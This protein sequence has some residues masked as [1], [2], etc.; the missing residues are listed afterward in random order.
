[1]VRR[2]AAPFAHG[3]GGYDLVEVSAKVLQPSAAGH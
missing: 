3:L 1:M 2:V